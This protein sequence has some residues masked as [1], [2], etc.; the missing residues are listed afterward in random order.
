MPFSASK[1]GYLHE[2]GNCL[3]VSIPYGDRNLI[4]VILGASSREESLFASKDIF[5]FAQT[6]F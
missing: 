5:N 3:S 4:A 6:L 2:A 1:T